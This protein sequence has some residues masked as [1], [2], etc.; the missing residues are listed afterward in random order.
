MRVVMTGG[1]NGIGLH[2]ARTLLTHPQIEL[3]IGTREP[4]RALAGLDGRAELLPLDLGSI[5]STE[6][7]AAAVGERPVDI[8][9]LN[10]GLQ[11]QRA[12]RSADGLEMTFAAN[13]LAPFLMIQR[14]L[15][16]LSPDGRVVITS[17]G[18]HDPEEKTGMPPPNHADARRLA[19]P[20]QDSR[21]DQRPGTAGRRAYSASKLC[22]VLT[23]AELARRTATSHPR[24]AIAAF[25]PGFNPGTGLARDYPK[26]VD[27]L[28]RRVLPIIIRGSRVSNPEL[29]GRSLAALA[30][31]PEYARSRGDYWSMRN[32]SLRH[33]QAS[34]LA[35]DPDVARKLWDDSLSLIESVLEPGSTRG[36][37]VQ[38]AAAA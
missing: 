13:H 17:S 8:L 30:L 35:R 37:E 1:T 6:R 4:D 23:A 3:V 29:S 33:V 26:A 18:T 2:A 14:L 25:D 21:L 7:F 12:S 32:K 27:W 22:N 19:F 15:D 36:I 9:I 24:L 16:R 28:F 34:Q 38:Q 10:A 31:K 20:E 11:V 5:G